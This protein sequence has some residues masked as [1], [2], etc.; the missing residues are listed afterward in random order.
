MIRTKDPNF[1]KT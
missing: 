1:E